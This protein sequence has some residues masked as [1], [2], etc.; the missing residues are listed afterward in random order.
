MEWEP[1]QKSFSTLFL[2]FAATRVLPLQFFF[3]SELC[4]SNC[5]FLSD[6]DYFTFTRHEPIGVCGQIIP[7]SVSPHALYL[8]SFEP[9]LLKIHKT[10]TSAMCVFHYWGKK[11]E[12]MLLTY[13]QQPPCKCLFEQVNRVS[14]SLPGVEFSSHGILMIK[15]S[16]AKPS[17]L[18]TCLQLWMSIQLMEN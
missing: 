15:I 5:S 16:K 10:W 9:V 7:V 8:F 6:G 14:A 17:V 12:L 4:G 3:L 1:W 2:L 11:T 13:L 18:I